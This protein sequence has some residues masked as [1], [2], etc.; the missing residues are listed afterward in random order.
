M[1]VDTSVWID[2]LRGVPNRHSVW[3]KSSTSRGDVG[4]T[5]LVLCE[6]LQGVVSDRDFGDFRRDLMQFPIFDTGGV[7]L[8][9]RSAQNYRTLRKKG[10]TV[11]RTID[12]IVAT[13]C[14]EHGHQ[15]LH[16]DRDFDAFQLH[17]GLRVLQP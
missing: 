13:F 8:A 6:I 16:S 14:I 7:E 17:L 10:Y 12:C 11:R 3:L 4:L 9:V 2:A 15:L 1:V 5:D